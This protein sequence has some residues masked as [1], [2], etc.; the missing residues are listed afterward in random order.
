MALGCQQQPWQLRQD[1]DV[2]GILPVKPNNMSKF[3]AIGVLV[4]LQIVTQWTD[5]WSRKNMK[6]TK[7]KIYH[8]CLPSVL[9]LLNVNGAKVVTKDGNRSV[10]QRCPRH[11]CAWTFTLVKIG[12]TE[13]V[14]FKKAKSCNYTNLM[15][16]NSDN[17]CLNS[18]FLCLS[19]QGMPASWFSLGGT[20]GQPAKLSQL[21]SLDNTQM[22][23]SPGILYSELFA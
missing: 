15:T 11:L 8:F 13:S 3:L 12:E 22:M 7:V 23:V 18:C 9:A 14:S 1:R 10:N 20:I 2:E 19:A 16:W 5:I 17:E 4:Q 6:F 21:Q